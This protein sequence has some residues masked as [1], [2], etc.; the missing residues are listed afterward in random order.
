VINLKRLL[1]F[2]LISTAF[3]SANPFSVDLSFSV[4]GQFVG[5]NNVFFR[6]PNTTSFL[7]ESEYYYISGSIKSEIVCL[8]HKTGLYV[9]VDKPNIDSRFERYVILSGG[10]KQSIPLTNKSLLNFHAGTTWHTVNV[11]IHSFVMFT[12][13]THYRSL[14]GVDAGID[15]QYQLSKKTSMI[16]G[17]NFNNNIFYVDNFEDGPEYEHKYHFQ[18]ITLNA[19]IMFSFGQMHADQAK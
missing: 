2:I 9:S 16:F 15:Y 7:L 18:T 17:L 11:A 14:P 19:G 13:P 3:L 6:T 12:I 4:G 1:I 10:I 5:T 8:F